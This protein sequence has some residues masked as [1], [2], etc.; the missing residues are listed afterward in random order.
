MRGYIGLKRQFK[1]ID[2]EQSG[3]LS[4]NEF[5][6]AFDDLKMTNLESGELQMIFENYDPTKT[7]HMQYRPFLNDLVTELPPQRLRLVQEAFKHL[8]T[9]RSGVLELEEVKAKYDASRHPYVLSKVK[10]A[11]EAKFEFYSLFTSLH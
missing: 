11:E 4:L 1:L 6:Q 5:L 2:S 8:D 10:T 7:G 3:Y 9:N